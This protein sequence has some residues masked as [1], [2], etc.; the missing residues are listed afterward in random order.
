MRKLAAHTL[1]NIPRAT[2][3]RTALYRF[4]LLQIP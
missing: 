1:R 4:A 2:E 3:E